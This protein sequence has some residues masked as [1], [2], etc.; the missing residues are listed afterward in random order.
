MF[1][2]SSVTSGT[3]H[4]PSCGRYVVEELCDEE[5]LAALSGGQG[6]TEGGGS[7]SAPSKRGKKRRSH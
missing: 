3:S 6:G 5:Q 4:L 1:P 7:R 2:Q